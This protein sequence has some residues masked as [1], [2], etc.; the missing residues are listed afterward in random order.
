VAGVR[1][2]IVGDRA[3]SAPQ[4]TIEPALHH[5]AAA[6]G[7][8]VS[9]EWIPTAS[10]ADLGN[11]DGVWVAPGAY[12]DVDGVLR[13]IRYARESRTPLLGTCAGFQHGV[14]ELARNV[15]GIADAQHAE[16]E[17]APEDGPL[18]I[19]EL[20]CSLAGKEMS[21]A[22]V[23]EHAR[24]LYGAPDAT[25]QYYCRFGLNEQYTPRLAE[26]GLVVAGIDRAD[27]GARIMRVAGHPFFYLT[28]FVPQAASTHDRPH[29]LVTG[30]LAM[31]C[32]A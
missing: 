20:L 14:L 10:V 18:I 5:S 32:A 13:A 29:P 28:L 19:D 8:S 22:L 21:V 9:A 6:V 7:T 12:E 15:L 26:A 16:Y 24:A 30:Y 25:E 31:I 27:G 1:V 4:E 2:A 3:R 11:Y 17:P 23:D